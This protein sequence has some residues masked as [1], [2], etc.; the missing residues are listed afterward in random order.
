MHAPS[1]PCGESRE[2]GETQG[3][4]ITAL[5]WDHLRACTRLQ[6]AARQ[7]PN[8]LIGIAPSLSPLHRSLLRG[9]AGVAGYAISWNEREATNAPECAMR[10]RCMARD[11]NWPAS[12]KDSF[13]TGNAIL[14]YR[15]SSCT[16]VD[17]P[18]SPAHTAAL[19][20]RGS[21]SSV[22]AMPGAFQLFRLS[23]A[24]P[25]LGA[26]RLAGAARCGSKLAP[27]APGT[28]STYAQVDYD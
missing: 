21:A 6:F 8:R 25:L 15:V 19:L 20:R 16:R 13:S 12:V 14:H 2:C 26:M 5:Q 27:A 23:H 9:S 11:Q 7:N 28:V 1:M 4:P 24:S 17:T 3:Q 18:V 22:A 10:C